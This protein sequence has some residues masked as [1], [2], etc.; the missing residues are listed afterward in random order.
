VQRTVDLDRAVGALAACDP[1]CT[2]A[3][4]FSQRAVLANLVP[5]EGLFTRA[6]RDQVRRRRLQV[7]TFAHDLAAE[8]AG[9][10]AVADELWRALER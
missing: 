6:L 8:L 2:D 7:P 10:A 3:A 1:S 4:T 9:R 5:G